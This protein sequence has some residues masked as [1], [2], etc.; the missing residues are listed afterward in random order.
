MIVPLVRLE[1]EKEA[2]EKGMT[3]TKAESPK[4]IIHHKFCII[5][6]LTRS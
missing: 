1:K 5:I 3:N 6:F 4:T 2:I